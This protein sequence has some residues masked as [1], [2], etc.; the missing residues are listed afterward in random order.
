M[1]TT[2]SR[3][4][5][6]DRR[7]HRQ[8][9]TE[10]PFLGF[11]D[12]SPVQDIQ[13]VAAVCVSRAERTVAVAVDTGLNA[14]R[15]HQVDAAIFELDRGVYQVVLTLR[16]GVE[17][18]GE[19]NSGNLTAQHGCDCDTAVYGFLLH[20]LLPLSIWVVWRPPPHFLPCIRHRTRATIY[21]KNKKSQLDSYQQDQLPSVT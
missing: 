6:L 8:V 21:S 15:V 16:V 9:G 13:V 7:I 10:K 12:D 20:V 14:R 18:P 19:V 11:V 1:G 17:F 3:L 2:L 4:R 5:R